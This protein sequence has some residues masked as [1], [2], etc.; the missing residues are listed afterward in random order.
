MRQNTRYQHNPRNIIFYRILPYA[1]IAHRKAWSIER[2]QHAAVAH[3]RHR[4]GARAT[5][6]DRDRIL[7]I[8]MNRKQ[9]AIRNTL[10]SYIDY[11]RGAK[12]IRTHRCDTAS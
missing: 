10:R 2:K 6:R 8:D 11:R 12:T 3:R 4:H 5:C 1:A 9:H 7:T